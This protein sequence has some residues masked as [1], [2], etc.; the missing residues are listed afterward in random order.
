MQTAINVENV[1]VKLS[2]RQLIITS[3]TKQIVFSEGETLTIAYMLEGLKTAVDKDKY[4]YYTKCN[5][6]KVENDTPR[7]RQI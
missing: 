5:N 7:G 6:F 3:G 2:D 4:V 1:Q